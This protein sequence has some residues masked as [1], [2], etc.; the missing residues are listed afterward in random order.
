MGND[1]MNRLLKMLLTLSSNLNI[2]AGKSGVDNNTMQKVAKQAINC[3]GNLY[4]KSQ[5][6]PNQQAAS[7]TSSMGQNKIT[8]LRDNSEAILKRLKDIFNI[9]MKRFS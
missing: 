1:T 4:N 2:S 3:I 9:Q 8:A 6:D 5:D 7:K